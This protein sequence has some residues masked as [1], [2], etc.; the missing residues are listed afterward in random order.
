MSAPI[1]TLH[2]ADCLDVLRTMLDE[3][4]HAIVTDPPYGLADH[5]PAAIVTALTAWANGDRASVPDGKGFMGR[6][7]DAFVPPPAVWDECLRVLKPGG[8]M[9]VFAG[10]RTVDL[11]GLSVRM[12]GFEIRDSISWL[13]GSGFPKSLDVSKAIDKTR[14]DKADIVRV[15]SYIAAAMERSGI[16]RRDVDHHMGTSDMAGWWS[17]RLAH[18]C[19]LPTWPQWEQLREFIG[20]DDDAIEAEVWRLNGRK[21][22]PG[23][24]WS[25]AEVVRTED[26]FN[27]PSGV[28]NVGQ[29]E[30]AAVTRQIKA[31]NTDAARQWSGWGTALKPASEPII[32]ARKPLVGTVAANVLAHGTGAVNV[33]E[34]RVAH[35][36]EA[37]LATSPSK[38][39]GRNGEVVTSAVYGAGRPQQQANPAGRWPTN[40]VMDEYVAAELDAQSGTLRGRGN[41]NPTNGGGGMYGHAVTTVDHG[42]G[43]AG[44]ASRFFPVFRYQAKAP[45]KERPKVNGKSHPTVK[46]LE[47]MRWLVRLVTPPGGTVL[48]PFAGSGTTGQAA[49][50]ESFECVLIEF[51]A[52]HIPL[53]EKRLTD[54]EISYELVVSEPV[55]EVAPEPTLLDLIAAADGDPE[56]TALWEAHQDEWTDE[57][58]AAVRARLQGVAA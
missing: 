9:L 24:A 36:S 2:Q 8:H 26:R 41:V 12:A 20:M 45:T 27:E 34:C 4:V 58:T 23:E 28:V 46:P 54:A 19:A 5:K 55:V 42:A 10:T 37:D 29:G 48:D 51:E 53:I 16:A 13:Y 15:T 57:H 35:T 18:R 21:G 30:R 56:M 32:V 22:T 25:T 7:W 38:N 39:P 14:D 1:V 33:D 44:G 43:D 11:M 50:L 49:A 3:S 17:S 47:L 40:V 52:D 31:P 6:K